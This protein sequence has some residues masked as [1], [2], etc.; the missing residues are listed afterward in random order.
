[1]K[2]LWPMLPIKIPEC[3]VCYNNYDRRWWCSRLLFWPTDTNLAVHCKLQTKRQRN[4][5]DS[6]PYCT[7]SIHESLVVC[8]PIPLQI[9]LQNYA[10][11]L[12]Q[13][14]LIHKVPADTEKSYLQ[15][16]DRVFQSPIQGPLYICPSMMHMGANSS[17]IWWVEVLQIRWVYAP[18]ETRLIISPRLHLNGRF[19]F[20]CR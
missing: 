12:V 2:F 4:F 5:T 15:P 13:W 8:I 20:F 6:L 18:V 1:M 16:L 14:T 3:Y 17:Y 7:Y 10:K 11:L 19:V 9:F